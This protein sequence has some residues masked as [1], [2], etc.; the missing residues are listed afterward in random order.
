MCGFSGEKGEKADC[1]IGVCYSRGTA[2][3]GAEESGV[4]VEGIGISYKSG[5]VRL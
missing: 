3:A 2:D 1:L 4:C 5:G